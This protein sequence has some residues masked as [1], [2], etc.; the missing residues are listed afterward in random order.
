MM[1]FSDTDINTNT[2]SALE[3][4]LDAERPDLVILNGDVSSGIST[5]SEL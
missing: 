2:I 5:K 4:M 3:A 1:V